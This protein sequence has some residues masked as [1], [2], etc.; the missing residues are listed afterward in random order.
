[1]SHL[2]KVP[3]G[4]G[5]V[6]LVEVEDAEGHEIEELGRSTPKA[7][8]QVSQNLE[9]V[10]ATIVGASQVMIG[11]FRSIAES[12]TAGKAKH[13]LVPAK[14]TL[15]FGIRF[16]AEGNIYFVKAS[17]DATLKAIVEWNFKPE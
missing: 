12:P 16:N 9:T 3:Y 13:P 2:I 6:I 8:E 11:A 5:K 4:D 15:E 7:V 14:A 10:S 1:M 17:G